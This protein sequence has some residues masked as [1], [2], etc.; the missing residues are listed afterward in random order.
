MLLSP[1]SVMEIYEK[2]KHKISIEIIETRVEIVVAD[3]RN[4]KD[5]KFSI[6]MPV[7]PLGDMWI[8]VNPPGI[9]RYETV[10]LAKELLES[11]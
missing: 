3:K 2:E 8:M 11:L 4:G 7:E 9:I 5:A 6:Y 10:V 1:P